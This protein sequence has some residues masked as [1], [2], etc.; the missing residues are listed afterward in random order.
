MSS[1]H[2]SINLCFL[3]WQ[4]K[5][6]RE[7]WVP[8]L[9]K[10][11]ECDKLRVQEILGGDSPSQQ[12]LNS[13]MS[14]QNYDPDFVQKLQ[15]VSL[16]EEK[17]TIE[18]QDPKGFK[19]FS[20]NI[21]FLLET[22][23]DIEN[24]KVSENSK[25]LGISVTTFHRW[26]KKEQSPTGEKLERLKKYFMIRDDVDLVTKPIFLDLKPIGAIQQR[27]WLIERINK[28]DAKQVQELFP[29]LERILKDG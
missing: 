29:A 10:W 4:Q 12:E 25:A 8:S 19:I 23:N 9:A 26:R 3:L 7:E 14:T 20:E 1:Q 21:S 11:M 6:N 28:M 13:L 17:Q 18:S 16:L 5:V 15:F 2:F 27:K 22:L 24:S